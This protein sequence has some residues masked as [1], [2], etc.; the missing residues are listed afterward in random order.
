MKAR[1]VKKQVWG[2]GRL[3]GVGALWGAV[4]GSS[5]KE[6]AMANVAKFSTLDTPLWS[7]TEK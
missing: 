5:R 3:T 1:D 2:E 6:A 7:E 4:P